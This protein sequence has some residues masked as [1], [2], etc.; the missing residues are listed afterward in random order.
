MELNQI[1]EIILFY[2]Q[3]QRILE[4]RIISVIVILKLWFL[5]YVP[6][7]LT[8]QSW[9][10]LWI[11]NIQLNNWPEFVQHPCLSFWKLIWIFRLLSILY[12]YDSLKK[13]VHIRFWN[14]CAYQYVDIAYVNISHNKIIF[15]NFKDCNFV[16]FFQGILLGKWI[17]KSSFFRHVFDLSYVIQEIGMFCVYY[18]WVKGKYL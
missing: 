7:S 9:L 12:F 18:L 14:I 5:F 13:I 17:L 15:I 1:L 4:N 2:L 6:K 8:V 10:T 11:L 16:I 3:L